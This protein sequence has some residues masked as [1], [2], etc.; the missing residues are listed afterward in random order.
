MFLAILFNS[1]VS[2]MA[3]MDT[4]YARGSTKLWSGQINKMTV[5]GVRLYTFTGTSAQGSLSDVEKR[6]MIFGPVLVEQNRRGVTLWHPNRKLDY[7]YITVLGYLDY[8]IR[9]P[10]DRQSLSGQF[11]V[12]KKIE[13]KN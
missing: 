4:G 3:P 6:A 10:Y 12:V 13:F 1:L 8:K 9:N 5:E 11:L 2:C 7:K